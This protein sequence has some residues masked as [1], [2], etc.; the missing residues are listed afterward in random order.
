MNDQ[1][2][3]DNIES[4]LNPDNAH[5]IIKDAK[6][7]A[8]A[9]HKLFDILYQRSLEVFTIKSGLMDHISE[10]ARELVKQITCL[11][12]SIPFGYI[13]SAELWETITDDEKLDW[14]RSFYSDNKPSQLQTRLREI[15]QQKIATLNQ[16]ITLVLPQG[17]QLSHFNNPTNIYVGSVYGLK[18][19]LRKTTTPVAV[20]NVGAAD[21]SS[22]FNLSK[23]CSL[24]K[25][26]QLSDKVFQHT[27]HQNSQYLYSIIMHDKPTEYILGLTTDIVHKINH[28]QTTF[29][30]DIVI[31]CNE[32]I[33][34]SPT[35]FL[36]F[37]AIHASSQF[38]SV[39]HALDHLKSLRPCAQPNS[40]F[41]T[42]LDRLFRFG[43]DRPPLTPTQI[44]PAG[45]SR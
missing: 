3:L 27:L 7:L 22:L 34:R 33:S 43:L 24:Y 19:F 15:E 20:F 39:S 12:Q 1:E 42:Q 9:K 45:I 32:G 4:L 13:Y 25:T 40:G 37:L 8:D 2:V 29:K 17:S 28:L 23:C 16:E 21:K 11:I 14:L 31:C 30:Y 26:Q 44:K 38:S 35:I 6:K 18:E 41:M 5:N 10:K 36:S